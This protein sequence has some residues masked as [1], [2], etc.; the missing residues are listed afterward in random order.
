MNICLFYLLSAIML[1]LNQNPMQET[2]VIVVMGS[3]PKSPRRATIEAF[4]PT[5]KKLLIKLLVSRFDR[6][7][8]ALFVDSELLVLGGSPVNELSHSRYSVHVR[9]TLAYYGVC[10]YL[11]TATGTHINGYVH[12]QL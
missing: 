12:S 4:L 1:N 9:K 3:Q 2:L 5:P 8:F 10:A 11:L 7:H 6:G